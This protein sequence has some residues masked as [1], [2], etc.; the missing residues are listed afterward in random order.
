M[1]LR[2]MERLYA[3]I[4]LLEKLRNLCNKEG[5]RRPQTMLNSMTISTPVSWISSSLFLDNVFKSHQQNHARE[6]FPD[7]VTLG[8]IETTS[9]SILLSWSC[10][11]LT[12]DCSEGFHSLKG[13]RFS[14]HYL[15]DASFT[16]S[17]RSLFIEP[18][19]AL[20]ME[21]NEKGCVFEFT[22]CY[23]CPWVHGM[24]HV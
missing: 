12:L 18:K 6:H 22:S 4:F 21:T 19:L 8:E 15:L 13:H 7:S 17:W 16:L 10:F 20:K 24:E 3:S 14:V 11:L 9:L 23:L 2:N 5:S 1:L